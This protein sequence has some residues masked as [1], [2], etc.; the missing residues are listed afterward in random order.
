MEE[1]NIEE[2]EEEET[3]EAETKEVSEESESK[4]SESE[5]EPTEEEE[6]SFASEKQFRSAAIRSEYINEE[7][8]RVRIALTSEAPV[9]RSFGLE[10]LDHSEESIDTSFMDQGRS[11]LLLD[12]DMTKQIGVVENFYLDSDGKR[13]IAEVRFGKSDLANEVFNDVKDGIRQNASVGYNINSMERDDSF[14]EP[15]YRVSWTPLESS[16]VS[17]PADQ[18][19]NVGIARSDDAAKELPEIEVVGLKPE[20][21]DS[22][23][24]INKNIGKTM[25]EENLEIDVEEVKTET[26]SETRKRIAKQSDEILEL[27]SRHLQQDLARQAIKD[28]TDLET[29][30]GQLLSAIPSGQPLETADIGLNEKESRNF[31]ILKAV[32][33]MSNPTNRKAQEEAK[34]EFEASQAAKDKYGKNSEGLTLPSEVMGSWTRDV[35]TSDD[36]G[37]IGTD[38]RRGD[39]IDALRDA[40]AVIRAGATI[41][42]DLVDLVKIPKQTGVST[43]AWIATEGGAVSES[44][45][46]LGSVTLS[47]NT[48]S[49]YTD[50]TNKMLANSSLSI[51]TLVRNDL[52]AGIG[53]IVDTGALDGSGS[54]GQPTGI[55]NFSGVNSVT[56]ATTKTPTWA[57]TVE[58]ESLVLADNVPFNR[59]AYLTTSGIVGNLKV[60]AKATNQ[61]IF[62]MDDEGRVNGHPVVISNAVTSTYIYFGMWTD[63][64][65]GFFG[66]LDILVDPYT[67]SANN[68][69]RIRATQFADVTLRHGQSFTKA[70]AA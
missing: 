70:A 28:G 36:A 48:I 31:S 29:F 10:I 33:A 51:E 55:N 65:I 66:G 14:D 20:A 50:I 60:T 68:L 24:R 7:D 2:I 44:E 3:K 46:T 45:L 58:M 49:A 25:K 16:I 17:I 62:I 37:G 56:L 30:R 11:P 23:V 12:H 13:T 32:Y 69:T 15:T 4:E 19:M 64:L 52:A 63:M 21:E 53:K 5:V 54:S 59:P 47:P 27:G 26:E 67:G 34:F 40:S 35:N 43:A 22:G 57:E 9:V 61:A 6:R 8:R 42:P 1:H 38:F 41:F 18:S 39:F